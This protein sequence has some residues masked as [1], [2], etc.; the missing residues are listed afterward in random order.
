MVQDYLHRNIDAPLLAW[1][2]DA[3]RKPL[4]LR[5]A[6]QVGKSS[7]A[8]HLGESFKYFIEVNFDEDAAVHSFFEQSTP[9]QEI[10]AQLSLYFRTPIVP[11]ETLLFFDEIQ[12]CKPALSKLRYFY[13]KYPQLHLIAAGSL[14]EF[15]VEEVPSFAVGRVRSLFMYPFS[16]DEFL[17]AMGDGVLA[18]AY[19]NASPKNPLPPPVHKQLTDRLKTFLITGGMPE[20][21]CEYVSTGD[22][23][24]SSQVLTD[25]LVTFRADFVKYRKRIPALRINEV[26]E[27]VAHQAQGKF[28]YE[29]AAEGANN[30]QVKQA[31]DLLMMAGL[32]YPVTHTAANGIPLGAEINPKYQRIIP[33]DTGLFQHILGLDTARLF[34]SDDFKTV[35]RGAL[36]EIF[37]GLELLKSS[38]C[39]SPRQL[40]CWHREKRQSSAQVDYVI[41][42]GENILP[43]EVKSGTRGAMQS[44]RLFMTEKKIRRGVRT[45]LEN[46]ARGDDDIDI[47][48]LYAVSN[49]S[50]G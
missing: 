25:L 8:R 11:G 44:L 28:I 36:A 24:H 50:R 3:K 27:S 10:C 5:G 14:L 19:K 40:Y 43:I 23:L 17:Y 42:R 33:C 41:Q 32:V 18:D 9:P 22:L 31:L 49:L 15:V 39:Y 29:H 34:M 1:S 13:E 30:A 2:K 35:N 4:L 20:A 21:V 6:R 45:S 26:F 7:A 37:A 16:F 46:F 47:Y 38:S 12:S 48:P